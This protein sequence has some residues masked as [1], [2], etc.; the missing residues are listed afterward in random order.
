MSTDWWIHKS[1]FNEAVGRKV[2]TG[3][4]RGSHVLYDDVF[5]AKVAEMQARREK[6]ELD[7]ATAITPPEEEKKD[8]K[9]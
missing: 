5:K 2:T 8:E 6:A 4:E 9:V 3:Y 7:K 1:R